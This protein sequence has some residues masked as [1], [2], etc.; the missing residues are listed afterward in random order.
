MTSAMRRVVWAI[1]SIMGIVAINEK[2]ATLR[3]LIT[4]PIAKSM[5]ERATGIQN[6]LPTP[7]CFI[8]PRVFRL[9]ALMMAATATI[10]TSRMGIMICRDSN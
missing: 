7:T 4:D 3:T 9:I 6:D 10:A 8:A 2:L 5:P 1:S